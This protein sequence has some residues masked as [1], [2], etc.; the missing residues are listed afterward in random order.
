MGI[1]YDERGRGVLAYTDA[2]QVLEHVDLA[3]WNDYTI[4]A[5]GPHIVLVING[6][7]TVDYTEPDPNARR[8]G[9]IALQLHVYAPME[10]RF[11]NIAI[12]PLPS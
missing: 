4:T 7:T 1:L 2:A 10:V 11:K 6:Y 5:D 12:K 9:V 3:G 8:A